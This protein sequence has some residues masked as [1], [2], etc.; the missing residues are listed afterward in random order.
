MAASFRTFT[1]RLRTRLRGTLPGHDA[2]ETMAPRYDAR[3]SAMDVADRQC[4]EAGVLAL[5][6]PSDGSP[7][8]EPILVLTRR[9]DELPDHGGQ[10]AFPGGQRDDGEQLEDTALR[11]AHEEIGLRPDPVQLLGRLTPLYIPPSNFCVHPFVGVVSIEP[12]LR[13]TD[14]EVGQILHA[15]IADLLRPES[16]KIE[17]WTLHGTDIDVPFYEVAGHVVWG[18]TAMMLAELIAIARDAAASR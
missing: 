6:Y 4:R 12:N 7:D 18:A 8:G 2:H 5:V 1:D 17:T 9:R 13:P 15:S 14:T 10:I 16:R 11:E 3:R